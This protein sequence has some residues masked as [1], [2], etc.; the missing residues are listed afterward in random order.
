MKINK[1]K[2]NAYG[3]LKDKEINFKNNI[4]IIYGKNEAGK[5]TLLNFISNCFYGI[6]KNKKGKDI[7]DFERYMPWAGEDFSGKMEYELDNQEKF[8]IFRDFRKKNPKIFNEEMEDISK[9]FNIDKNR[10]NEFFYE[11]TK[12]DEALFLSTV[13]VNQQEVKLEKQQQNILIQKIANLVGTGEDNVSFKR[14]MDRMDRRRLDEIGT[15][16][17]RERPINIVT[18]RIDEL[19]KEKQELE[20]Y[21]NIK[22]EIEED[23]NNLKKQIENLEHENQYLKE[24]KLINE[25]EK[26][27]NEKIKLKENL[28]H[29]NETK[30]KEIKN[31]INEIR[32]NHEDIFEENEKIKEKKD[33]LNKKQI[34]S[35][36]AVLFMNMLQFIL[37]P[38]IYFNCIFLLTIPMA[39]IF[40]V[41]SKN[42]ITN[43]QS[44]IK[45]HLEKAESEI[46]SLKQEKELLEKNNDELEEEINKLKNEYQLKINCENEKIKNKYLNQIEETKMDELAKLENINLEIQKVENELNHKKIELHTLDL[47]NKNIEPKLENLSNLEEELVENTEKMMS[48]KS[49]EKSIY[50]AKEVLEQSYERMKNTVTPKFTEELSRTIAEITN[51][52]Y[53][54]VRLNDDTG[55]VVESENG[56]YIP[57]SRL[58]VGTIDQLYL[59]LRLAMVENLSEEK[60][61][62]ILDETFA[63]YDTE[64]L[65]NILRYIAERFSDHQVIIF[66]CTHRERELLEELNL[67]FNL[68]EM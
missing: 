23:K 22:Y 12:V 46:N 56:N 36:V 57:V 55:L 27:E 52:K 64:R 24:I 9:E 67:A 4:N 62:I 11:Q 7:S 2:I 14:A 39:L 19:E 16:R 3:K 8:E 1:L 68:V 48:L 32:L 6:S 15:D 54:K 49:L 65:E 63:Y 26:I 17:S 58:S 5:S 37:I 13:V 50:L 29:E 35:F 60:M 45:K 28:K 18:K 41:I 66:T 51:G 40:A 31:K 47:D 59:S 44:N 10:G 42:K 43:K 38:N 53:N 30:T 20:K 25:N 33:T 34:I 61:P 21:E